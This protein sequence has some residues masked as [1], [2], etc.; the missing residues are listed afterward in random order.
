LLKHLVDSGICA[1]FAASPRDDT[2]G[3]TGTLG[4]YNNNNSNNKN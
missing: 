1:T 2:R 4:R 3:H